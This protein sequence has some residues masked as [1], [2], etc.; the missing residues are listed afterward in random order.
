MIFGPIGSLAIGAVPDAVAAVVPPAVGGGESVA[1][2][3]GWDERFLRQLPKRRVEELT[4][5]QVIAILLAADE[6]YT[7]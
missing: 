7:Q 2:G 4:E 1:G 5:A 6:E 3:M